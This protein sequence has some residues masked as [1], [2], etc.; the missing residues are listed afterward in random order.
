MLVFSLALTSWFPLGVHAQFVSPLPPPRDSVYALAVDIYEELRDTVEAIIQACDS[1]RT[2]REKANCR[3][4][5][6]NKTIL[7]SLVEEYCDE[8][9]PTDTTRNRQCLEPLE[10]LQHSLYEGLWSATLWLWPLTKGMRGLH[11]MYRDVGDLAFLSRFATNLR[12]DQIFVLTDLISGAIGIIP[13]AVTSAT[14]VTKDDQVVLGEGTAEE[15]TVTGVTSDLTRVINNGGSLSGR[16]VAPILILRGPNVSFTSSAY[17]QIGLLGPLS[18]PDNLRASAAAVQE[19]MF[20]FT[21]R[22]PDITAAYLG[23]V[24]VGWRFGWAWSERDFA[25]RVIDR[26]DFFFLQLAFG[27]LQSDHLGISVL[28]TVPIGVDDTFRQQLPD[29]VVNLT[30][31]RF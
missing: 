3:N 30:A 9:F 20:R 4:S 2:A 12:D 26:N 18:N 15:D 8:Q 11:D 27:L 10:T 17:T 22:R 14:I 31:V 21:I 1:A 16:V 25:P 6:E 5:E 7:K 13:F 29:M 23:D 24:L 28:L 19:G